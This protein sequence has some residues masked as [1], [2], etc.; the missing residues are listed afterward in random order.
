MSYSKRSKED[1]DL[2]Y[3]NLLKMLDILFFI[4]RNTQLAS[5]PKIT[6]D[7]GYTTTLSELKDIE[8]LDDPERNR[9]DILDY[10]KRKE[11]INGYKLSEYE[12]YGD[13]DKSGGTKAQITVNMS[14][15]KPFFEKTKLQYKQISKEKLSHIEPPSLKGPSSPE[16]IGKTATESP[17]GTKA[18]G[19]QSNIIHEI[20]YNDN[21]EIL[22]HNVRIA[23]PNFNGQNDK[24]FMHLF[25][26]PNKEISVSKLEQKIGEKLTKPLHKM[27]ENWGFKGDYKKIFFKI[28]KEH[29]LFRNPIT[30]EVLD[31][32]GIS[33]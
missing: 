7:L 30:Q 12:T 28:S 29:I 1:E 16:K 20:K 24:V 27:V 14:K 33:A 32:M 3:L 17:S 9:L 10:L 26:N 6:F 23:K 13:P 15:F 4:H 2:D 21:G 19:K 22:L 31:K 18:K 25:E 5:S 8:E 11:I